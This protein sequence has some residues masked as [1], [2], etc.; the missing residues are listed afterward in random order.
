VPR[1]TAKKKTSPAKK[2][3]KST[4]KAAT[5][6]SGSCKTCRTSKKAAPSQRKKS[7]ESAAKQTAK[8]TTAKRSPAPKAKKK[9]TTRA[10]RRPVR[11]PDQTNHEIPQPIKVKSRLKAEDLDLFRQMLLRKR[12]ELLGTVTQL[13]GDTLHKSRQESAGDL[14]SMPIHM[15]DLGSDNWEQEFTLGL[16]ANE[17]DLIREIDEALARVEQGVYG[18]CQATGK[19][20]Q[21]ARL[22]A[23]PWA[24]YCIEHARMLELR[25]TR[26]V[27]RD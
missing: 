17:R 23:K 1:K 20:I 7:P 24:K 9:T 21:K 19:H 18:V 11:P 16:L 10:N 4:S 13:Q 12:A 27:E 2:T 6:K 3:G 25:K 8:K 15:A 14:S 22:R 26:G 5:K